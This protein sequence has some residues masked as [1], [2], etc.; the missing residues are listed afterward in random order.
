V[1]HARSRGPSLGL[2]AAMASAAALP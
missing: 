2:L 1:T